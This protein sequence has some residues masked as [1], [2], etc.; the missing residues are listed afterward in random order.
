MRLRTMAF[1]AV[2]RNVNAASTTACGGEMLVATQSTPDSSCD[3]SDDSHWWPVGSSANDTHVGDC[4]GWRAKD[5]PPHHH[6]HTHTHTRACSHFFPPQQPNTAAAP[7][8]QN[9]L[10]YQQTV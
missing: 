10:P 9:N 6:H 8:P 4:H 7:P 1:L 2:G 5:T 3:D